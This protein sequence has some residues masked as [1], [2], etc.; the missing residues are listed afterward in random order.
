M[1]VVG[2]WDVTNITANNV[3]LLSVRT[4]KPK[5]EGHVLTRHP[6]DNT[7]GSCPILPGET[8]EVTSDFW[9]VPP[10]RKEG[11]DFRTSVVFVDQYGN[12]HKIKKVVFK[13]HKPKEPKR[14]V[15]PSE[16]IHSISD[17][18]EKEVAAVLKAEVDRY[19]ACGRS[20]GGLGSI[21]TTIQGRSYRGVGTEWREADSPKNQS[22]VKDDNSV[23]IASDNARALINLYNKLITN[24]EKERYF[25]ALF[26]RLHK[27][28]EY[29]PIGYLILY[30][31]F[32]L[33]RLDS[34]LN[35]AVKKLQGDKAHGFSDLLRLLDAL[36]RFRH[37][38]F[39]V[40]CLDA[41]ERSLINVKEHTFKIEERFG[42][43]TGIPV[44]S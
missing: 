44:V 4:L 10:L 3:R 8:T 15:P 35:E 13:G 24:E 5:S 21:Q 37:S 25:Q 12:E 18:I 34:A 19:K 39:T 9:I 7:F 26:S 38:L 32:E 40:E 11:E 2:Q 31:A 28:T 43:Y 1:Q 27:G 41:I 30:V 22:I 36:L 42:S 33:N 23:E 16:A 17:P 6:N 29:A 14:D 20:I